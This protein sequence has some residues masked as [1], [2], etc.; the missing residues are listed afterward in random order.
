[1]T[2]E[3]VVFLA[4]L[5]LAV[6]LFSYNMQRLVRYMTAVGHPE[7]RTDHPGTRLRNLISIG[8]LQT[9]ILRDRTAGPL[10]AFVFWGFL[11][12]G[13]GTIEIMIRGLWSPFSYAL[14]L[15]RPLYLLYL[16]SQEAFAVFVLI[17]VSV[18]LY[19]RLVVKPRR[20][21]GDKVHS[22][23]AILI[24]SLIAGI[25]VT[26]F[27]IGAFEG[28]QE[29]T[30]VGPFRPVSLALS[31]FFAGLGMSPAAA[32]TGE[33]VSFWAHALIILYFLNHLPYSKHLHVIVSLPNVYLSN[34]S[35]PGQVGVMRAM[36]LE[37]EGAEQFGAAD[38]TH[39]SWK[40]LLDGYSCTECGR[41]T[42]ACPA[43][44]TGKVLSPRKIMINTR[45]R[46]MELAPL[47]VGDIDEVRK[48]SL[49]AG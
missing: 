5:G 12:L 43:N 30:A 13:A 31:R 20:L 3:N 16:I 48:P 8:I 19:R 28:V 23:D 22:G 38:V 11:V 6:G 32:A 46:L 47:A 39:L 40:N 10:H 35:G 41:C 7:K 9:K 45:Q 14:I 29:P 33:R 15:P 1:M 4:V 26:L 36:D 17:A 37:A 18:L 27:L 21:Q 49:Q 34:T 25:M 2:V 42:A 24:L 44:L